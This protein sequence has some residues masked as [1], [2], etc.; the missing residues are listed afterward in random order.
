MIEVGL[1]HS[2]CGIA[3]P[4]A[5]L[6]ND[7]HHVKPAAGFTVVNENSTLDGFSLL[8]QLFNFA[9]INIMVACPE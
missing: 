6:R 8:P 5:E 4:L 3:F 1:G 2:H 9:I 7:Q